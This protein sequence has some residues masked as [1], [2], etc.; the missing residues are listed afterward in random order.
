MQRAKGFTLIELLVVI[1]VIAL[2]LAILLPAVQ[3]VRRL[4]K[5]AVCRA[6]LRQWA[7]VWEMYTEENNSKFPRYTTERDGGLTAVDWRAELEGLYSNDRRILLC[8]MTTKTF[9]EGA[10]QAKY[11]IT[12]DSIWGRRSSYA[13]NGW[14]LDRGA[15]ARGKTVNPR[16][17]G[18]PNVPN[19][20]TV[21]IMGDSCWWH[22]S[23][24]DPNDRPPLY[25]GEPPAGKAPI[26]EMRIFCIDR[27]DGAI[28]VLFMDSS[29][30]KVGLKKLWTLKWHRNYDTA[31]SWTRAGGVEPVDWP[32]WMRRFKDY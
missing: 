26:S 14:I 18:T 1:A 12:V 9:E 6:T 3:R 29:V 27:H 16:D 5:A 23:G 10:N 4:A 22:R 19:A 17:W 24:P 21:P 32:P 11:A 15:V 30:R 13:V 20:Y 8:P 7:L 2:L 28:D 31:G 25:D